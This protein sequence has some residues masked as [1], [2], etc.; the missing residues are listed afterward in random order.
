MLTVKVTIFSLLHSQYYSTVSGKDIAQ[1][2]FPFNAHLQSYI[3]I[4]L[5]FSKD[6]KSYNVPD[7]S[8]SIYCFLR[9]QNYP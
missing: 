1:F 2:L 4:G 3:Y 8:T 5:F 6:C 9:K 7:L